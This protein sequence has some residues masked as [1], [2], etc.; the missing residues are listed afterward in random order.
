[1]NMKQL[2]DLVE[3][4]L[5]VTLYKYPADYVVL[6]AIVLFAMIGAVVWRINKI[7]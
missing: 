7:K 3:N 6:L 4:I 2:Q 1:M 5:Q